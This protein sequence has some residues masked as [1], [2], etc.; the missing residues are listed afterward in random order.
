MHKKQS[1]G[2]TIVELLIV[3]V[4][5]AILAAISIVAY[6]GIQDRANDTSVRSDLNNIAKKIELYKAATGAYPTAGPIGLTAALDGLRLTK[7]SYGN[8]LFNDSFN[9]LY[10][11]S[12]DGL[13]FGIAAWSKSGQGISVV[14]STVQDLNYTA[15]Q[16]EGIT[17]ATVGASGGYYWLKDSGAWRSFI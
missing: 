10:C 16:L 15:A 2:F 8:G 17:C 9:V 6:T 4:I 11:L 5:I 14:K 3:I 13:R 1:S 7:S 12:S